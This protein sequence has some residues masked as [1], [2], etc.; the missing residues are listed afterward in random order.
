MPVK[1][2]ASKCIFRMNTKEI[3]KKAIIRTFAE[4]VQMNI[5]NQRDHFTQRS[6]QNLV[7]TMIQK[8]IKQANIY[9]FLLIIYQYHLK[10]ER[11]RIL[12]VFAI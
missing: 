12:S 2:A 3:W 6:V 1:G 11:T 4:I 5:I 9:V 8:S 10:G 7:G